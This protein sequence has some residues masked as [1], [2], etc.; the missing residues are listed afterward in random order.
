MKNNRDWQLGRLPA[1]LHDPWNVL[2][3]H[4]CSS[5]KKFAQEPPL[6]RTVLVKTDNL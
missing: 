4:G 1:Y 6:D 3:E 5:N 2:G